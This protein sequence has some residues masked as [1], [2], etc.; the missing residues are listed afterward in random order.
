[1]K[2]ER[3]ESPVLWKP[4]PKCQHPLTTKE[5]CWAH[6]CPRRY[7]GSTA[8]SCSGQQV[9]SGLRTTL[10]GVGWGD[11]GKALADELITARGSHRQV[12]DRRP[13]GPHKGGRVGQ[14]HSGPQPTRLRTAR[15]SAFCPRHEPEW[16]LSSVPSS[17]FRVG[18]S[19]KYKSKKHGPPP[20]AQREKGVRCGKVFSNSPCLRGDPTQA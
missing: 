3:K 12:T 19:F 5:R 1:M 20:V 16:R 7:E 4:S 11:T 2:Q 6:T 18:L 14:Q 17:E 9:P 13:E 15:P 8:L 10:H